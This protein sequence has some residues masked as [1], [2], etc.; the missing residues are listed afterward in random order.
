M[1]VQEYLLLNGGEESK[2]GKEEESE[3]QCTPGDSLGQ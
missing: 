3:L 2:T 1:P